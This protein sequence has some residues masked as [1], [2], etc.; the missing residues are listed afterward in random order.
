MALILSVNLIKN[1]KTYMAGRYDDEHEV[2]LAEL[3][4]GSPYVMKVSEP[5]PKAAP[6]EAPKKK[7]TSA[8]KKSMACIGSDLQLIEKVQDLIGN[9]ACDVSASD[10]RGSQRSRPY[11]RAWV[12][13]RLCQSRV[14]VIGLSSAHAGMFCM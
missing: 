2:V 8:P 10:I 7:T 1:G 5:K 4:A 14:S 12:S 9:I 13:G 11:A 6:K 3:E